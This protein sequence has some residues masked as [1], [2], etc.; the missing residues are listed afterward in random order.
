MCPD[1]GVVE[2]FLAFWGGRADMAGE[3]A[4]VEVGFRGG[5][6]GWGGRGVCREVIVLFPYFPF[7][8]RFC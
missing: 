6:G 3:G 8:S 7:V 2:P 1:Q 5:E 4:E